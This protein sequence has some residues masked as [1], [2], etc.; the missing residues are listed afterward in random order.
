MSS[1][2]WLNVP[3][4]D[5]SVPGATYLSATVGQAITPTPTLTIT[6]QKQAFDAAFVAPYYVSRNKSASAAAATEQF[7][8]DAAAAAV[9]NPSAAADAAINPLDSLTL[10]PQDGQPIYTDLAS[11]VPRLPVRAVLLAGPQ[12]S[13]AA[14]APSGSSASTNAKGVATLSNL[15]FSA[16]MT[17]TGPNP[18]WATFGG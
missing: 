16:G 10:E 3:T 4:Y 6:A 2:D 13:N 9:E 1:P 7:G 18:I 14:L 8:L 11:T 15:R 17:G 12:N 5:A